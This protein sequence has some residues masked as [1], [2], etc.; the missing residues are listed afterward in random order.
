MLTVSVPRGFRSAVIDG[1]A[2]H[3]LQ[4]IRDMEIPFSSNIEI[5]AGINFHPYIF[6]NKHT[7]SGVETQKKSIIADAMNGV[8]CGAV[9]RRPERN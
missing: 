7:D 8:G 9:Y 6:L 4:A 3:G 5:Y 2:K 1:P